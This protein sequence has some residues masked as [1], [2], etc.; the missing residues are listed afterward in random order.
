[1]ISSTTQ[2]T[3]ASC[4]V[5]AKLSHPLTESP[6]PA[7]AQQPPSQNEKTAACHETNRKHPVQWAWGACTRLPWLKVLLTAGT[8]GQWS[9][10]VDRPFQRQMFEVSAFRGNIRVSGAVGASF[11]PV[12]FSHIARSFVSCILYCFWTCYFTYLVNPLERFG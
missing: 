10:L 3:T 8:C 1:M 9:L 11:D 4:T 7:E 6:I 12:L 5:W 2:S